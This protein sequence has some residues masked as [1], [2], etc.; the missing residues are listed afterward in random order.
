MIN[1]T[2]LSNEEFLNSIL[3]LNGKQ[4]NFIISGFSTW[5]NLCSLRSVLHNHSEHA[6]VH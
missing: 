3:N 6:V 4:C 2:E 5:H 1:K